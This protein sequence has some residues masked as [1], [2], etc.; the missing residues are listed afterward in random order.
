MQ[1]LTFAIFFLLISISLFSQSKY[2]S[3]SGKVIDVTSKLP[4][5]AASVFAENTTLGTTTNANGEFQLQLPVGGYDLIISYTGYERQIQRITTADATR[6]IT[7]EIKQKE[8]ALEEVAIKSNSEVKNGWEKYGNFFTEHFIGNT[9]NGKQCVIKNPDS[10]KFFFYRKKNRL[11]ILANAPIEIENNALGY[12]IQYVLDSFAYEYNTKTCIYT[13]NPLFKEMVPANDVQRAQWQE[14]RETAYGGS[15]LHLMRSIYDQSLAENDFEIQLIAKEGITDSV[16]K[17]KDIYAAL[18]YD[19][20][21]STQTVE[22]APAQKNLAILY[23][24]EIPDSVYLSNNPKEPAGF[25]LSYLFFS[26]NPSIIIEQNGY[27]YDQ[28]DITFN[29]WM[30]WEKMGDMLPY[31]F[32][33]E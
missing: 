4:L 20:D 16:I 23:K 19:M 1:K 11:K 29:G 28:N 6:P 21:D 24:Y 14:N 8:K 7:I 3:I 32:D 22:I 15:L 33:A 17:P 26:D 2:Y 12:T 13:G 27:Y 5:P 25:Q 10:L 30:A 9:A 18:H 31:D